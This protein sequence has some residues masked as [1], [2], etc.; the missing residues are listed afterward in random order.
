MDGENTENKNI[1]ILDDNHKSLEPASEKSSPQPDK[2]NHWD[3]KVVEF[4][5]DF[6]EPYRQKAIERFSKREGIHRFEIFRE[7]AMSNEMRSAQRGIF[8]EDQREHEEWSKTLTEEQLVL[9][10]QREKE[11]FQSR[12]IPPWEQH[13]LKVIPL[14]PGDKMWLKLAITAN[15]SAF[16]IAFLAKWWNFK[17]S[18][19]KPRTPVLMRTFIGS[20]G[21]CC[22]MQLFA[23]ARLMDWG[24]FDRSVDERY[25]LTK[26][27]ED[28]QKDLKTLLQYLDEK[29]SHR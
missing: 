7:M 23:V 6:P 3:P 22:F 24:P 27:T 25:F 28:F 18:V 5:K 8:L 11:M 16:G 1:P 10:R 29:S 26:M 19:P 21:I 14:Q 15:A 13:V 9:A 17:K 2:S 4:F 12:Y 20:M